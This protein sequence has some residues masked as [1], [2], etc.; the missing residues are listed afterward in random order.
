[1]KKL[2]LLS[3]IVLVACAA[4]DEPRNWTFV[5]SV[6]GIS[7]GDPTQG[8]DEWLLPVRADVSGL[9]EISTKPTVMLSGV[10]CRAVEAKV[11]G[12]SIF[13]VVTTTIAGEGRTAQC[14]PAALGHPRAGMYAVIY[15]GPDETPTHLRDVHINF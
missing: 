4:L 3:L 6:G 5:Q 13:I 9:R 2:L 10:A 7:I 12:T 11:E 8:N 15:R 1:M 14:P